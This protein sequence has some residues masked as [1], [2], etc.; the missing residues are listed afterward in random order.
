MLAVTSNWPEMMG[1]ATIVPV[2]TSPSPQR[3]VA[4]ND[5]AVR[6]LSASV[7]VA[8]GKLEIVWPMAIVGVEAAVTT[9][10]GS[11]TG[12]LKETCLVLSVTE[13]EMPTITWL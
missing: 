11:E 5:D 2:E 12:S 6:A 7:K 4:E 13:L 8:T 10:P 9:G 3:T 1:S